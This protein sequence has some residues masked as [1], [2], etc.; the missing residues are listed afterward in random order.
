ME[1]GNLPPYLDDEPEDLADMEVPLPVEASAE[2]YQYA[3]NE[4]GSVDVMLD[5]PE[6]QERAFNENL[7]GVLPDTVVH[8]LG[9]QLLELIE[10]DLRAREGRDKQYEEG[11]K[12]TGTGEKAPGGADFD[13]ASTV[14][15]PMLVKGCVDFSSRAIK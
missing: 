2:D 3:E 5:E 12:R 6:E 4:D 9:T 8:D 10:D 15:H 7:A 11:I 1:I 14:S 13:G